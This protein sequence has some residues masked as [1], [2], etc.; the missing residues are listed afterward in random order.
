AAMVG[1]ATCNGRVREQVIRVVPVQPLRLLLYRG[2][3][4][5]TDHGASGHDGGAR[6]APARG[7]RAIWIQRLALVR[8]TNSRKRAVKIAS[9]PEMIAH[10]ERAPDQFPELRAHRPN[11]FARRAR[12]VNLAQ[13]AMP[14]RQYPSDHRLVGIN[15]L[16]FRA[17][18]RRDAP[19]DGEPAVAAG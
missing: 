3:D 6:V 10:G 14:R 17:Q 19:P 5:E 12:R 1:E 15:G 4:I 7:D 13:L 18:Q 9:V 11:G 8:L 2:R 16:D